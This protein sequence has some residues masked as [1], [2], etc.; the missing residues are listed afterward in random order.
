MHSTVLVYYDI[1]ISV[2]LLHIQAVFSMAYYVYLI[3]VIICFSELVFYSINIS[4]TQSLNAL[5]ERFYTFNGMGIY[6]TEC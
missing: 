5:L 6:C 4:L 2:K 1:E 3:A